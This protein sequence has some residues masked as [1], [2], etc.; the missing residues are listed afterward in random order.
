MERLKPE[1]ILKHADCICVG[2]CRRLR[3]VVHLLEQFAGAVGFDELVAV[4]SAG[5]GGLFDGCHEGRG[6]PCALSR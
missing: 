2:L 3:R 1:F 6:I 5:N 4:P